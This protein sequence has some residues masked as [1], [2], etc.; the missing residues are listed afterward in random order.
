MFQFRFLFVCG[1][2][3]MSHLINFARKYTILYFYIGKKIK[4]SNFQTKALSIL[5]E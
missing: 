4:N 5:N 2:K 3:C 1:N